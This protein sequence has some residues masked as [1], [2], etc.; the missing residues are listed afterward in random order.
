[1]P[2]TLDHLKAAL[3]DRYAI[4]RELGSGGMATVYLA[5]DLKHRRKVAV[6][7][8]RPDLAAALGPE[9]FLRE[10]EIAAGFNHPHILPLHDSG[11]A[12]GL[13]YYVMPYVE[14]ESLR[15]RLS[16]EGALPLD[17][18]LRIT[19]EVA[20]AL[21]YAHSHD[22]VHRD[23]KPENILLSAGEAVVAD[24][25]IA[26]AISV[27][28]ADTLT[29][30]G[31]VVGTPA[32]MSPEQV[33][34]ETHIDGRADVYALGCVLYEMLAGEPPFTGTSMQAITAKKLSDPVPRLTTVRSSVP[35]AVE[36]I[37]KKALAPI[38]ADRHVTAAEFTEEINRSRAGPP[39]VAG[40]QASTLRV[41]GLYLLSSLAVLGIVQLL[42]SQLGLPRWVVPGAVVLLLIGL[43]IILA[44]AYAQRGAARISP[45]LTRWLTWRKAILGGVLAFGAWGV[46]VT[47]YMVLRAATTTGSPAAPSTAAPAIAVLPFRVVGPGL[48]LWREGMVD[49]LSTNF[50]GVSGLRKIDPRVVLSRWRVAIGEG[51]EPSSPQEALDVA[52]HVGASY[53]VTGSVVGRQD[54]VRL[55]IEVHDVTSGELRGARQVDGSPDSMLVLVDRVAL[56][57]LRSGLVP[58]S[59]PLPQ[60]DIGHVTTTSLPALKAYLE[61][62]QLYRRSRW[63]EAIRALRSAVDRDSTF[64]VALF[65]LALAY[66]W[67]G[68]SEM[69]GEYH[70]RAARMA[71]RL[72]EREALLLR[73]SAN[74]F[75]PQAI[76]TLEELTTRYPDD[77]E[78]W[79][80]LADAYLHAGPPQLLAADR[81]RTAFRHAIELEPSFGPAYIHL[82]EDA[83]FREDSADASALLDDFRRIDAETPVCGSFE[84]A[85]A[86]VWGDSASKHQASAALD[87]LGA[88]GLACLT[89]ALP[90]SAGVSAHLIATSRAWLN[91]SPPSPAATAARRY[92]VYP[93]VRYGR[94]RIAREVLTELEQEIPARAARTYLELH[95]QG[96]RDT[97]T[98]RRAGTLLAAESEPRYRFWSGA[99][100]AAEQ[101]WS[102]V[103]TTIRALETDADAAASQ[104][105]SLS[106]A[107]RRAFAQALG[108]YAALHRGNR[109][110][111]IAELERALPHLPGGSPAQAV[112]ELL[113]YDL[114][115]LMLDRGEVGKAAQYFESFH[116]YDPLY[117]TPV[118]FYLG[119]VYEALGE[120]EKA[121]VHYDRFVR[122]W[123][124]AD[125]E[126]RPW[127][128]EG[129]A[130]LVRLTREGVP[131][132]KD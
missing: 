128:E 5:E 43:P 104:G 79:T 62:E 14:G 115:K 125:P 95:L 85:Y 37:I 117:T 132:S 19:A 3:A 107:D 111:A 25:G 33:S 17:D 54:A 89:T 87:T 41:T 71:G 30:T 57:V 1:M 20:S 127:W 55:A 65:R 7:V 11:A 23:I 116:H 61:G 9:R 94:I 105:D 2:D 84:L 74:L 72:P 64:A 4:E 120:F 86:L 103:E 48:E 59:G 49:L 12:D 88:N 60:L 13:L 77:V 35:P 28:G 93:A 10:I 124:A 34:G 126:L 52:R 18:A 70:E 24:F 44:T 123:E 129:R 108:G 51:T 100:A 99:L 53:A 75:R 76:T 80:Q 29:Q 6:K 91:R 27:A 92:L 50:E 39:S 45:E 82:I 42:V 63:A 118:Q 81:F 21:S 26:R 68:P 47:A 78:G 58:A 112:Q 98:A 31:L 122:W 102:E 8:L 131:S 114:G 73:G 130:A 121:R 110:R 46:V 101:R 32:Y 16:R 40:P 36:Q 66:G 113:R 97:L 119:Q 38:P 22:V 96:F 67:G 15:D 69:A 90:M 56:E 83:F 109:D 106:A